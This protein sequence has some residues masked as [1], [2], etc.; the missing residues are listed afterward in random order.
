VVDL[1]SPMLAEEGPT[2]PVVPLAPMALQGGSARMPECAGMSPER[3]GQTPWRRPLR[4]PRSGQCLG[5]DE[6]G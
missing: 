1:V 2:R 6:G 5:L 4:L 3:Q